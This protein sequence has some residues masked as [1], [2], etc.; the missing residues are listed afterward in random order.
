MSARSHAGLREDLAYCLRPAHLRRTSRIALVVGTLLTLV[1]QGTLIVGGDATA[2]TWLRCAANFLIPLVV[3]NL[4]LL[5][6]RATDVPP[7]PREGEH[8]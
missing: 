6:G 1:N 8:P 5:G 7:T 3:S 4:G 2:L